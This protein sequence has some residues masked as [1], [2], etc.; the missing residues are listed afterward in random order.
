MSRRKRTVLPQLEV[1]RCRLTSPFSSSCTTLPQYLLL[2]LP[3]CSSCYKRQKLFVLWQHPIRRIIFLIENDLPSF[4]VLQSRELI[5]SSRKNLKRVCR[6]C[7]PHFSSGL[8]TGKWL[9]YT[10]THAF[11]RI[12]LTHIHKKKLKKILLLLLLS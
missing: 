6:M 11:T 4:L 5:F 7:P 3:S 8:G 1:L 9:S 10:F 2:L 12:I